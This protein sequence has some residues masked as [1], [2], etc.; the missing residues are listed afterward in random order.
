[1]EIFRRV[2]NSEMAQSDFL[3]RTSR[4]GRGGRSGNNRKTGWEVS[5]IIQTKDVKGLKRQRKWE[6]READDYNW[7]L[8]RPGI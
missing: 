4:A 1:M 6:W 7:N 8:T 3:Q 2:L 5:T